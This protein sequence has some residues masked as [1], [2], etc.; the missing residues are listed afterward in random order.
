MTPTRLLT[1]FG[2]GRPGI[3]TAL[4]HAVLREVGA[5]RS[6]ETLRVYRPERVVAFG[7]LDVVSPLYTQAV[8]AAKT[9]GYMPIER[10]AGGRAAAFH[11]ETIAFSWACPST[12]P[13]SGITD[14][15]EFISTLIRDVCVSL[16]VDARVGQ[17][18][19]EYCPGRYSVNVAGT[20]KIM[21][22]GQRLISGAAHVGGVLVVGDAVGTRRIVEIV[23][24]AM[25]L[26]WNPETVGALTSFVETSWEAAAQAVID[27]FSE[28]HGLVPGT[29]SEEERELAHELAPQH[30]PLRA[31]WRRSGQAER[32]Q[33]L[34]WRRG[35]ERF[36]FLELLRNSS[37]PQGCQRPGPQGPERKRTDV[38]RDDGEPSR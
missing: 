22:V 14:R 23:Y 7:R 16:G 21:G 1:D 6:P 4:S 5:G 34:S 12:D 28:Q 29:F 20:H 31:G 25:G 15:F 35:R 8:K 32:Q 33:A 2:P 26:P 30:V 11:P 9:A 24:A 19:G 18:P 36:A 10:L 13:K 3:D 37:N 17:I 27:R 38:W